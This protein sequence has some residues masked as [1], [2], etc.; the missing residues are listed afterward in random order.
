MCTWVS[1][2]VKLF[3]GY[4]KAT[5]TGSLA[6]GLMELRTWPSQDLALHVRLCA[7]CALQASYV[8]DRELCT[9]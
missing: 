3:Y 9:L 4:A 1:A 6:A 8:P 7:F 5:P 2:R